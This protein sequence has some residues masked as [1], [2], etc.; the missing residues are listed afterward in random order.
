MSRKK[1]AES[2]RDR[3]IKLK[4]EIR[5]LEQELELESYEQSMRLLLRSATGEEIADKMI[6][7]NM[8]EIDGRR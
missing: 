4:I 2:K 8:D 3:I 6:T 1:S 7:A 5:R